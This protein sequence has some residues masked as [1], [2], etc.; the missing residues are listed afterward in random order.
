[1]INEYRRV[2]ISRHFLLFKEYFSLRANAGSARASKG[3]P[4]THQDRR[5]SLPLNEDV[6]PA[7][8]LGFVNNNEPNYTRLYNIH[9]VISGL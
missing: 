8:R 5:R 2:S 3:R 1:M 7:E 6:P 9:I 4:G